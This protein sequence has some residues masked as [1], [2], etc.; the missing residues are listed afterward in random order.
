MRKTTKVVSLLLTF[1][2]MLT[3]ALPMTV[4][5]AFSDV[6]SDH[7]YYDAIT[8]LSAEGILDGMGDGTFKPG[9]PVTRAQFTKI[10][11]YALSV[12]DITHS[13]ADRSIF[14]DL[15]PEHW[16]AD[17]I[18][19]AYKQGIINGMGDG[20]FAPEAGVQ[21]EQAVKMV[22]CALGYPA[23]RAEALG[24]YPTGYMSIANSAK[25]LKGITDCK[26]G[27]V[28]NRGAVAKLMDNFM[29]ADQISEGVPSGSIRD[30]SVKVKQYSGQVVS[31]YEIALHSYIGD[32]DASC[33]K[34]Q[35]AVS[36]VQGNIKKIDISNISNFDIDKYI[37][38]S[39]TVFYEEESGILFASSLTLQAKKNK[40]LTIDLS[41]IEDYDGTKIEYWPNANS[42]ETETI[43]YEADSDNFLNGA[44]TG[45][46][47]KEILDAD[48]NVD[49]TGT[50][51]L[52]CS[53]T[54]STA[55]VAF[56]KTY[57]MLVVSSRNTTTNVV[58]GKNIYTSE[59]GGIELDVDSRTKNVTIT[60][61]V[62]AFAL[63]SLQENDILLISESAVSIEVLVTRKSVSGT[64]TDKT[65]DGKLKL[66]SGDTLYSVSVDCDI[67][68]FEGTID[69]VSVGKHITASLDAFGKIARVVFTAE[70][71]YQY[72][73]LADLRTGSSS[74]D[75]IYVRIY[76][77]K[78][79]NS[80]LSPED[81]VFANKVK[82]NG[83]P[84]IVEDDKSEILI[85]LQDTADNASDFASAIAP[86]VTSYSQP[87]RY[88][89]DN[90][91][92]INAILTKTATGTNTTLKLLHFTD[93]SEEIYCTVSGSTFGQYRI[94]SSTP[95]IYI[96]AD[97]IDG[98]YRSYA[99]GIF[100]KSTEIGYYV[101]FA[102][103]NTGLVGCVY[104]YGT[105]A[106]D[107][108]VTITKDTVPMIVT[109]ITNVSVD[110]STKRF[111]LTDV[112]TGET[113]ECYDN[114]IAG[115]ADLLIGDVVRVAY[116][117][118]TVEGREQPE[119]FIEVLEILADAE[120]VAA[121]TFDYGTGVYIKTQGE[122]SGIG[123]DFRVLIGAVKTKATGSINP[124]AGY[125]TTTTP[126]AYGIS[127]STPIYI[128]DT[129][130]NDSNRVS[131][132]A[133][134]DEVATNGR[135]LL[136]TVDAQIK[137]VVYFK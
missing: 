105:T 8:N 82:I 88:T 94:S 71:T 34:D 125:D 23:Q 42:T 12:G 37:G 85:A 135:I 79:S 11:C 96:P 24:G 63:S 31:A 99:S 78:N 44:S 9:D 5:A 111:E 130:A 92:N 6:P 60:S 123:Y 30:E 15:A 62:K 47:I 29:D 68:D 32:E 129:A 102:N 69:D 19:T 28:M 17:N 121:G 51:T 124:V 112:I 54:S 50:I 131:S 27:E 84:Y 55:D 97:R 67:H 75:E 40:E 61:G 81:K 116:A 126:E 16:A 93:E 56:V 21:Y 104:Y 66:D 120:E 128:I 33:L 114:S 134:I 77:A 43:Y 53:G 95:V 127:S 109:D 48:G 13:E 73:Y 90:R 2:M 4:S 89:L 57:Q 137:A 18:V 74:D 65:P 113:I 107:E 122:G 3:M 58:F 132:G 110:T 20:T 1:A 103:I 59:D 26:I 49:K 108:T 115:T 86:T 101:Q 45:D 25:I 39:V 91:G 87:I 38:R 106:G 35:I 7:H 36:D 46:T 14:T 119:K 98:T 10:I 52:I 117:E 41:M 70:A 83:E 22:V 100:T 80:T 64:I 118:E 76:T 136:Y 72:G 133:T